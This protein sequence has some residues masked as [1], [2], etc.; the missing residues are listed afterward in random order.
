MMITLEILIFWGMAELMVQID[1]LSKY[2]LKQ[3]RGYYSV[4]LI[5]F[6]C[7]FIMVCEAFEDAKNFND[8]L[9][10]ICIK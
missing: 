1:T 3:Y 5:D 2:I 7:M 4:L 9:S 8:I 6:L 10:Y